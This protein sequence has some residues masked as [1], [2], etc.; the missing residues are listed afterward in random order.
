MRLPLSL[1]LII[2]A[3]S[4]FAQVGKVHPDPAQPLPGFKPNQISFELPQDGVPRAESRSDPFYAVILKTGKHCASMEAERLE[5]QRVFASNKVFS[6]MWDCDDVAPEDTIYYSNTNR[7]VGFIAVYAGASLEQA[8]Q[9]LSKV[10][11]TGRFPGANLRRM[12]A[13]LVYP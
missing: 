9:F 11:E 3:S 5:A 1:A 10:N 13:V 12:Q 7:N 8:Q 6:P 4:A 2:A